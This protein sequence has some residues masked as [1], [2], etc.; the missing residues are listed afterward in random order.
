MVVAFIV[1]PRLLAEWN[2]TCRECADRCGRNFTPV[3]R[4]CRYGPQAGSRTSPSA[5]TRRWRT[6]PSA[7][8]AYSTPR[9]PSRRGVQHHAGVGGEARRFV[10]DARRQ[11]AS[12]AASRGCGPAPRCGRRCRCPAP[13]RSSCRRR[14]RWRVGVVAALEGDAGGAAAA[15]RHLVDLRPAAAVGGEVQRAAVGAPHRLGV[16]A[17]MVGHLASA[18][19]CPGPSRRS[20]DCRPSTASSPGCGRR[21]RTPARC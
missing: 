20:R 19:C 14:T 16:D 4:C 6:R 15:G 1:V 9:P 3:Q 17:E 12:S 11:R 13:W 5:S 18:A 7:D 21:A 2:R 10:Q 8:T